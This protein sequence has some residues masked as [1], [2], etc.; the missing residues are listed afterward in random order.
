MSPAPPAPIVTPEGPGDTGNGDP[1]NGCPERLV[2]NPP[3][4]PP[5][6]Q[7]FAPP[8]PPPATTRYSTVSG[9]AGLVDKALTS[10]VPDEVNTCAL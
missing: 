9:S 10:K 2:F 4:P 8:P 7:S 3:A 6:P 1:A 5:P